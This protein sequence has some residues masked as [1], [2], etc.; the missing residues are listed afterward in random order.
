MR[1]LLKD[2]VELKIYPILLPPYQK[3]FKLL[4]GSMGLSH[5][6]WTLRLSTLILVL[7]FFR[8]MTSEGQQ[9]FQNSG[10][11]PENWTI[12]KWILCA[13][14]HEGYGH[15]FANL[16][17]FLVCGGIVES[18][19]GGLLFGLSFG[20]GAWLANPL[21]ALTVRPLLAIFIPDQ[22]SHF[23]SEMDYGASNG[24]YALVGSMSV[25]LV[26]PRTLIVPF[27]INGALYM[28]AA[29][30]WLAAQHLIA[31]FLGFGVAQR[32]L[33]TIADKNSLI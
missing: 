19:G 10:F 33:K 27:V 6:K 18:L 12:Q 28:L 25:F 30:S 5:L 20:V 7:H 9:I 8:L 32:F 14:F 23:L 21:T 4:K 16:F 26:T 24:I 29:N 13:F 3:K 1:S 11:T 22:L 2:W 31:L 15:F 17:S